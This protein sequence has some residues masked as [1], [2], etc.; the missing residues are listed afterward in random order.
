MRLFGVLWFVALAWVARADILVGTCD[1]DALWQGASGVDTQNFK[2]G[3]GA[4]RWE[5]AKSSSLDLRD[6]PRDW[7]AASGLSFWVWGAAATGSPFWVIVAS[8]DTSAKGSDYYS[9]SSKVDFVGWR[10]FVIP[11]DELGRVRQPVGWSKIDS[12]RFHAAWDP[13][14]APDPR[15]VLLIDDIRAV[16]LAAVGQGPRMTDEE[17]WDAL[18]LLRPELAAVG[19]ALHRKDTPGAARALADQLRRREKPRWLVDFRSRPAPN[20]RYKS[21]EADKILKRDFT[22]IKN[23]YRPTGRI[24]WAHNAMTEGE[25]ATVEWNAQFNRHFHFEKLADAHW[26]TGNEKYAQEIA[27][28]MTAWIED[29]PVLLWRSGNSPYHHAWETLNTGVR[30]SETWPSALFRCL[31][32]PAFTP[33]ALVKILKSWHEQA[34]HLVR[35]PSRNNWLTCESCG[36]FFAGILFPEFKRAAEWRRI[37]I[38]RLYG[39]LDHEV[40]PDGLQVELALGYN[41]WVLREFSSV[42]NVARHNDMAGDVPADFQAKIEKM[43]DYQL[44]AMRPDGSVWGLNDASDAASRE[45]LAQA[46]EYFPGRDDFRW[47]ASGGKAGKAPAPESVAMPYSGHYIMRSGWNPPDLHMHFDAGPFGAGHQ[48]EDKLGVLAY[49][50]GKPLLIEGGVYMY[51]KSRWRRYVLSTRAHNTI[52]VDGLDQRARG[53]KASHVLPYPFKP[54]D[55]PWQSGPDA[56]FVE[57]TYEFGYGERDERVADVIH[58]RAVLFVKPKYWIVSDVLV[59]ADERPHRYEA[60]FHFNADDAEAGGLRVST[61]DGGARLHIVAAP[62]DGLGARVVKGIAEEPVQ[63]W[64]NRPWRPVPTALYEW[65]T[66]GTSRRVF[67]IYPA[68]A[69]EA[70]PVKA[71]WHLPVTAPNGNPVPAVAARIEFADGCAHLFC[72]ADVGTGRRQF[73]GWETDARCALVELDASGKAAR[74][75]L[76]LGER[77]ERVPSK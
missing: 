55:N 23:T 51:D 52:R 3:K 1:D 77:I 8:E 21:A 5:F 34:E 57:G 2:E 6:I 30:I 49:A 73:G 65:R 33:E 58:R 14:V 60:I 72:H 40:Y 16:R 31:D 74:R 24:D 9:F 45:L 15:T 53:E 36:V 20:P 27:A 38:D 43:F 63:G 44:R 19:A 59:P 22:F 37:A 13:E 7:S 12:V 42:L 69:G 10:R 62:A 26:N 28:Q 71:V 54:L 70:C 47:A 64:A 68:A 32:S 48:H 46:V 35:W 41:N 17:F 66:A 50:H 25:S 18:D 67:V 76:C 56:D 11:F 29:C 4:V 75:V 61:T 39:Q